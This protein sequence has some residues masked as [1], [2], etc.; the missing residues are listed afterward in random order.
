MDVPLWAKDGR[1]SETFFHGTGRIRE[2]IK[3]VEVRMVRVWARSTVYRALERF[4]GYEHRGVDVQDSLFAP[5]SFVPLN[6]KDI[7]LVKC[8]ITV[9]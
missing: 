8:E 1:C 4:L 6:V 3:W 2:V 5:P 7:V 9:K